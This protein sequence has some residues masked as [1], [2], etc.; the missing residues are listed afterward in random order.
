MEWKIEYTKRYIGTG[1]DLRVFNPNNMSWFWSAYDDQ[2]EDGFTSVLPGFDTKE[3][4]MQ[5]AE[6]WY[7][8][9][10]LPDFEATGRRDFR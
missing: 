5:A 4:A 8:T 9:E 10:W 1:I 7:A 2:I 3:E 6:A